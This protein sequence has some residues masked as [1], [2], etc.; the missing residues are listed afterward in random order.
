MYS[1]IHQF[2]PTLPSDRLMAEL[3]PVAENIVT[4]SVK[5]TA[6]A[7]ATTRAAL[8]ELMRQMNSYYSN[9]IEGQSTHPLNIARALQHDFS[10]RPDEA[11]LQRIALAH[12]EAEQALEHRLAGSSALSS[13]FL[14]A[15]HREMYERLAP[16]DRLSDDG[17]EIV[18]GRLRTQ[19]VTVSRHIPPAAASLPRFLQR[20]DQRYGESRDAQ[21]DVILAACVHHRGARVHP[22]LDGNG[23]ATR[24]QTHCALWRLSQGLWSPSRGFARSVQAYYT[25]LH[26]ADQP[27]QGA[28]DGRGPLSE[29]GLLGWIQYFLGICEDQVT[30]MSGMLDLDSVRQRIDTLMLQKYR[31]EAAAPLFHVFGLGPV[32][33]GEFSQMTGLG[34]RTARSLMAQLLADG[35]LVSDSRVGPV[36]IGLPLDTL[37]TLFPSLYPEVNH[38]P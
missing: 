18:P 20:M 30:F 22:F 28:Y 38:H 31:R 14:I 5:L 24:L 1:E 25:A 4:A 13:A 15:A 7:H 19:E 27:M 16:S 12:I 8:R 37:S 2:E 36:R 9:R 10:T 11:R 33:R 21:C 23:R 17:I 3:Y 35:L 6:A 34:E 32:S 29:K 26:N